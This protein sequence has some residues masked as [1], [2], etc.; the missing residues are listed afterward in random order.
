MRGPALHGKQEMTSVLE[1]P[2]RRLSGCVGEKMRV[3]GRIGEVVDA[4][5][6]E[7]PGSLE[8]A[9]LMVAAKQ[10][11]AVFAEYHDVARWLRKLLHVWSE[12]GHLRRQRGHT[13]PDPGPRG[14]ERSQGE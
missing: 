7:H 3:A 12:P 11:F 4:V 5:A 14:E 1:R 8:E 6:L 9:T 13:G 2:F 10:R